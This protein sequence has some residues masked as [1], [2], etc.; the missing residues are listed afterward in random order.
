MC[1]AFEPTL[2]NRARKG[3]I[4]IAGRIGTP[5]GRHH[6]V[7]PSI[8]SSTKAMPQHTQVLLGIRCHRALRETHLRGWVVLVTV[9]GTAHRAW[10]HV[11]ALPVLRAPMQVRLGFGLKAYN[12]MACTCVTGLAHAC[13]MQ[14]GTMR[15]WTALRPRWQLL[16]ARRD[17]AVRCMASKPKPKKE[18]SA[19][20]V[21]RVGVG[22]PRRCL[23]TGVIL[24]HQGVPMGGPHPCLR[25]LIPRHLQQHGQPSQD[26]L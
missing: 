15:A 9:H 17:L 22:A 8:P 1:H 4:T 3:T 6:S 2:R 20:D 23:R 18:E 10:G 25:L 26:Q 14:T 13:A 11:P 7:S 12:Y 19:S 5:S 24:K 16:N 21:A